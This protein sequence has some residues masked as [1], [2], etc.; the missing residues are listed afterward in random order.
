LVYWP[1]RRALKLIFLDFDG[2]LF[3][4]VRE[5]YVVAV[6]TS[7]KYNSINEI[8]FKTEHYRNFKKLRYLISPAWNYKYL[9]EELELN[10]SLKKTKSNFLKS[11]LTAL[12]E[13]YKNFES[14]FF[15]T[16]N[17]LKKNYYKEW[18]RLNTP[19]SFLIEINFLFYDFKD[20]VYIVTTKD[21]S[22]V[23]R[24]LSL[25]GL[26]FEE[27]RIFD[28]KDYEK[29][30]NKRNIIQSLMSY[31]AK[32]IFIDDSDKHIESCSKI[33]GI[34]CF[35]P[36]WGYVDLNSRTTNC[37]I[38]VSEINKLIGRNNNV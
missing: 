31:D 13:D 33:R 4:T 26:E 34:Q 2:V 22:T 5:A 11:V 8:D 32:G 9:L 15:D 20:L 29:F 7:K 6:I 17:N 36:D 30:G 18:S 38:I 21:K 35:Q 1:I 16:R 24:L 12:K 23:L 37:K 25:E 14:I 27:K 3:D 19:F 28:N 10:H